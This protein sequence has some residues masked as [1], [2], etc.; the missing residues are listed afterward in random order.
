[1]Q[2]SFDIVTRPL[3]KIEF[4]YSMQGERDVWLVLSGFPRIM[5]PPKINYFSSGT[6]RA[7][8]LVTVLWMRDRPESEAPN[9]ATL[10]ELSGHEMM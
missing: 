1:M 6:R 3:S 8:V 2:M 10:Q 9:E 7:M 5:T 4:T